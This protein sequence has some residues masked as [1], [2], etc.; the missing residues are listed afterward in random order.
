MGPRLEVRSEDNS[1][2]MP[3]TGCSVGLRGSGRGQPYVWTLSLT[4]PIPHGRVPC[5]WWEQVLDLQGS[6]GGSKDGDALACLGQVCHRTIYTA[7]SLA[8]HR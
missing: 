7:Y 2:A 3:T 8:C 4:G 1:T 6:R 5:R